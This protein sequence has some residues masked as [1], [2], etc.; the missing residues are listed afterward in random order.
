[1][2]MRRASGRHGD[3]LHADAVFLMC[4]IDNTE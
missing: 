1:M 3:E 4:L 2:G